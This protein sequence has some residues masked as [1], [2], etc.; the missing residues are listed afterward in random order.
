MPSL[1]DKA[2]QYYSAKYTLSL[3]ETAY[4][5]TLLVLFQALGLS[6]ILVSVISGI[7]AKDYLVFP[8]YLVAVYIAYYTLNFPLNFYHS[9]V[10]EHTFCLSN[11]K[12]GDWLK[13]QLKSA[14]IFYLIALILFWVFYYIL[15]RLPHA[16]WLVVSVVW[17][18]FSLIMAKLVPVIIIPLFFKYKV[19]SDEILRQRIIN[20]S[21]K[22]NIKLLN[23]FEIDFSK[24]TL[25]ANAA[26]VGWGKTKRVL[27]AD[28]LK[29]KYSHDEIEVILAHEFAHYHLKHIFKLIAIN[30][31]ITLATFYLIFKSSRYFLDLLGLSSLQDIA[32]FP[33]I[34][35]YFVIVGVILGPL[36]NYFSRCLER[37]A[38]MLALKTTGLKSAF[39]SMMD[40]LATQNL[41]DRNPSLI[42]KIFFFD[43]PAIDERIKIAQSL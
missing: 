42:I 15:G 21:D 29:D 10:L 7:S 18:F 17:I 12:I 43:H 30:S 31:L 32:A 14:I 36:Q 13:D 9:F 6:K 27:L 11:Q 40:K 26:F 37:N 16:W 3:I 20:L 19:L 24:K 34:I 25:K 23:V 28:T 5:I 39:I 8:L 2:K 38:D 41:A 1:Q 22:M 4:I 33:L 35:I